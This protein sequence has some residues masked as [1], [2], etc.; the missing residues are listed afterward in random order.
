MVSLFSGSAFL[1]G[2]AWKSGFPGSTG[3]LRDVATEAEDFGK[4]SNPDDWRSENKMQ[5]HAKI[6]CGRLYWQFVYPG[7]K[8]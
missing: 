8:K 7:G 4:G 6:L 1:K 3:F 5:A 2:R